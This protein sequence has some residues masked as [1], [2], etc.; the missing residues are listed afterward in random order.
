[1]FKDDFGLTSEATSHKL[2]T[3]AAKSG[4]VSYRAPELLIGEKGQF[5]S[6]AEIWSFGYIIFEIFSRG[7]RHSQTIFEIYNHGKA[8]NTRDGIVEQLDFTGRYSTRGLLERDQQ[9]IRKALAFDQ[10]QVQCES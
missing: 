9:T 1:L 8:N 4:K 3:T 5:N 6:K 2:I 7:R 10:V